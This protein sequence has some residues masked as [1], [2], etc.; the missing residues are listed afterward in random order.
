MKKRMT[1]IYAL[2][3]PR[4]GIIRYVGK[5]DDLSFRYEEHLQEAV[6]NPDI[7]KSKWISE[8]VDENLLPKCIVL[9]E[10]PFE[11]W[12]DKEIYWISCH[13]ET[14]LNIHAGGFGGNYSNLTEQDH[15]HLSEISSMSNRLMWADPEMKERIGRRISESV[16]EERREE[17]RQAALKRWADPEWKAETVRKIREASQRPER[18]RAIGVAHR[19]AWA[20]P[21]EAEKRRKALADA[22]ADPE[23]KRKRLEKVFT[24][25]TRKKLSEAQRKRYEDPEERKKLSRQSK[26]RWTPKRKAKYKRLI[27]DVWAEMGPDADRSKLL[28]EVWRRMKGED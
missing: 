9:E 12:R 15:Q 3:D 7:S 26:S 23:V 8:L 1:N 4:D 13:K 5:T 21:V 10:V 27:T 20:D 22:W 14:I 16:T 2:V 18:R 11:E 6:T 25:E 17:M 28:K 24:P 19:K